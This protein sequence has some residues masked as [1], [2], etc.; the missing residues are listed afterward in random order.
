MP[1][2]CVLPP[3]LK[4]LPEG[5]QLRAGPFAF[6]QLDFA[7]VISFP[8]SPFRPANGALA[9]GA[10]PPHAR[11]Q[12]LSR[13]SRKSPNQTNP[14]LGRPHFPLLSPPSIIAPQLR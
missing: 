10:P 7:S 11:K 5:E 13:R 8:P 1:L 6:F 14:R 12:V 2:R 9:L 4:L 3:L